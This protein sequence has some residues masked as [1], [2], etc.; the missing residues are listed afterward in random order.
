M[1]TKILSPEEF[2][3]FRMGADKKLARWDKIVEYF[4]HLDASPRVKVMELGK[5]TMGNPFLLAVISSPENIENIEKIRQTSLRL[6]HPKGLS[7]Q[8]IEKLV[9]E[10]KALVSMTMSVHASEIGGSQMAPELAYE[11]ATSEEPEV[12]RVLENAV[13]LLVP[14]SN[15]DGNI[16]V[17]DWY[18][19]W[20]GTEYEGTGPPFLYHKYVGH[21][22]NRD[23]FQITQAESK[24]LTKML[25][26]DWYPQAQID[27]HHMG[28]YGARFYIPPHT[29]PLYEHSDPLVWTEQQLYGGAMLLE[30]EAA[31]KTGVET[32]AS[33][34]ADGGPYWD[35]SPLMHGIC[36][37]LTESASASLATPIY[38]H[39]QQ[40]EPSR[41][42]RPEYRTQMNFPHPWPGGW[43]RLRD[44]VEQ[45]KIAAIA[46]LKTAAGFRE[47]ILRNMYQKAMRQIEAGAQGSPYAFILS[48][49]QHDPL[50]AYRLLRM[51]QDADV[52]VHRAK[53]GF[54]AEG[55]A[56]PAGSYVVFTSQT[57]RPYVLRLLKQT[58]YHVGPW[59][60]TPDGAP[61]PPY[62]L[63]TNTLGEFMGVKFIEASKPFKG[64]FE[65][66]E[67]IEPP[68]GWV[69][70]SERGHLLDA[71]LNESFAVICSLLK[72]G[73]TVYHVLDRVGELPV[74]SF[75]VPP[76]DG[77]DLAELAE[78]H[79]VV[80]HAVKQD[81]RKWPVR[82]L[83][84]GM[85]QRYHGGSID[86][87]W[88]RWLLEQY[89]FDYTTIRDDD[90][91]EKNGK[92][93]DRFDDIILPDDDR[94]II[95]GEN[96]EEYYRRT[97]PRSVPP[98][99][100]PE[101]QSGIGKEGV[102]KLRGFV[103]AGGTLITLNNASNL[104]LEDL[105]MPFN[106]A[107]KD[108]PSKDFF[109]PGS[110]LK[111][112]IDASHP[113]TY[114]VAEDTVILYRSSAPVFEIKQSAKNDEYRVVVSYPQERILQSGWLIGERYLSNKAAL[115][116]ARLGK[117]HVILFGF[118]PQLRAMTAATFKLLFNALLR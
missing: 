3:G 44:V 25:F 12:K 11:L 85:Y 40:L 76:Q 104:A 78:R 82:A 51:L 47:R 42:G 22:N 26:K 100:P 20:L 106:N 118:S 9:A 4:W 43:W 46:A 61:L 102:E 18:N 80:F 38:I 45:Q 72:K 56:Y 41:R 81:F 86:E 94:N 21:D 111:V 99:Y 64:S 91:K 87:G 39:Y 66:C 36:G 116:D 101:Y 115:I 31:G 112:K 1:S 6:A 35:E 62:D 27:F 52:E 74:G 69:V 84:I 17:V 71:R 59:S 63:A 110:T 92:L 60:Q 103:E 8:G 83:R 55:A 114:G 108:V 7:E 48:P 34:P 30:L 58:F 70:Q 32:Q 77:L 89:G 29:D 88:T 68:K 73:K 98:K 113:L 54:R 16:I 23:C 109:C 105:K 10:G 96:L 117:G 65:P 57:C 15:P 107:V 75:Y 37:M 93:I 33:Y 97:R 28:S 14:S 13:L 49:E 90:I 24:V 2:F 5:T 95:L 67:P 19:R 79:G 53:E 50:T